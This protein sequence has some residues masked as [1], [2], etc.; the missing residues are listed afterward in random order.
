MRKA[1]FYFLT[2]KLMRMEKLTICEWAEEDRPREKMMKKGSEALS[3]AELMAILIGSGSPEKSAVDLM[4]DILQACGNSLKTLGRMTVEELCHFKGIGP[5]KAITLLAACALGQRRKLEEAEERMVIRSPEDIYD[6]FL[7]RMQDLYTEECWA[8]YLN[9]ASRVINVC[10]ISKGGLTETSVDIRCV[11][12]KA[13]LQKATALVLCHN[14]P[15]GNIR[16]S[17]QDDQLTDRI[18]NACK[19]M[20]LRMIDHLIVTDGRYYSYADEGRL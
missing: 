12:E 7:P 4:R 19:M 2:F 11:L 17:R 10:N 8:M 14:H 9:N 6:Y 13:L 5:A 3:N 18:N 20:N 15:S 16:P 1:S